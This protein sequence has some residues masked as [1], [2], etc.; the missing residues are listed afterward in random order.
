MVGHATRNVF[1]GLD[2]GRDMHVSLVIYA[3]EL[4]VGPPRHARLLAEGLESREA[5][6]ISESHS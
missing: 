1:T 2:M 4:A 5:D 6:T 3:L